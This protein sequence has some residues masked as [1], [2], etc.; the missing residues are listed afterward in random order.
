M[1][2]I[3][4][5]DFIQSIADALQYISYYHPKDYIDALAQAY[6]LEQSEAAKDAMG[7]ILLNSRLCA[8]GHRRICQDTGMVVVFLTIGMD[9][10]WDATLSI[11]A[12]VNQGV[13]QAYT[14]PDNPLRAS[15]VSDPSGK[16]INTGD[17]TPAI[18]HTRLV[19][20][21]TVEV[22]ISAKGGGSE[23]KSKLVMLNPSDSIADW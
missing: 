2:R 5:T 1:T 22:A 12:M 15:M 13:A 4:Q 3:K 7:Q 23:N 14:H 18:V 10:S 19:P 9:V 17:N 11:E 16:R 8:M 6:E 21:N 20:G